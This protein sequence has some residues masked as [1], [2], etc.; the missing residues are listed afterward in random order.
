MLRVAIEFLL[1]VS[2]AGVFFNEGFR[3]N[4]LAVFGAG[5]IAIGSTVSLFLS[6]NELLKHIQQPKMT[7]EATTPLTPGPPPTKAPPANPG[8]LCV[9]FNNRQI[10]E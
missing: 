1:F 7:Q 6:V 10:C 5:I 3:K 4:A 8:P 2:S 9:T